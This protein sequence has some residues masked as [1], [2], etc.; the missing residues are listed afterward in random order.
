MLYFSC[1][2]FRE[3]RFN[4]LTKTDQ[5]YLNFVYYLRSE[6]SG[7]KSPDSGLKFSANP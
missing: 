1:Q 3:F 4:S 7:M 5:N 6:L 2:L